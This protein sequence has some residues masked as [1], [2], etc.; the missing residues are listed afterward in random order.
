MRKTLIKLFSKTLFLLLLT[1]IFLPPTAH[2]ICGNAIVEEG[3]SCDLGAPLTFLGSA[4]P[5]NSAMLS[6]PSF[7][8]FDDNGGFYVT[9]S[10]SNNI[11]YVSAEG[12][13]TNFLDLPPALCSIPSGITLDPNGHPCVT[14]MSTNNVV[15]DN[16]DGGAE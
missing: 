12:V 8:V 5:S 16:G 14:C 15:C 1:G 13:L 10:Q 7:L 11:A 4:F 3:E 2:A 9:G 6:Y